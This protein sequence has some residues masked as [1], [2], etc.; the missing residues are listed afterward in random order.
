MNLEKPEFTEDEKKNIM[1]LALSFDEYDDEYD[2]TYDSN[3]INLAGTVGLQDLEDLESFSESPHAHPISLGNHSNLQSTASQPYE[4]D[5]I[6]AYQ[7]SSKIFEIAERK[8]AARELLKKNT[9]LSHEQIEGWFRMFQKN[10]HKNRILEKY[11]WN[12]SQQ[13]IDPQIRLQ[14]QRT[15]QRR[16]GKPQHLPRQISIVVN[17]IKTVEESASESDE[18]KEEKPLSNTQN[19]T[20]GSQQKSNQGISENEK[21]RKQKNK[22]KGANHNR[23]QGAQRK[24]DKSMGG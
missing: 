3:D 9:G 14:Q 5:L 1:K 21:R 16:P 22:G 17:E 19:S 7:E 6:L 23:K 10:P 18:D 8:S 4:R 15:N 11:E 2:D 20:S 12:G 13:Q 24:M